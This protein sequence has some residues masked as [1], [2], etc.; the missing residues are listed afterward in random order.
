MILVFSGIDG[1]G[2]TTYADFT[3]RLFE[4][5]KIRFTSIHTVKDSF[6][7]RILHGVIGSFSPS[8]RVSI[9]R[10]LRDPSRRKTRWFL[11]SVKLSVL[12]LNLLFFDL[13]YAWYRNNRHRHLICDRYF[14]DDIVQMIYL[15]L[16]SGGFISFYRRLIVQPDIIFFI[17]P[18]PEVAFLRKPEYEREYFYKKCGIYENFYLTLPSVAEINGEH[19]DQNCT[20][21]R[22]KIQERLGLGSLA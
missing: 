9:E 21:I 19:I 17:K 10:G 6:Y 16:A 8:L 4:R 11:K 15:E 1:S 3:K 20:V 18:K 2:K 22:E 5:N 7:D 13:R 12:F 14:Y